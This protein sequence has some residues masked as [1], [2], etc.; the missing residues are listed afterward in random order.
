MR[1]A[2][3]GLGLIIGSMPAWAADPPAAGSGVSMDLDVIAEQFDI[4][5]QQM[6]SQQQIAQQNGAN[7]GQ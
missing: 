3:C 5:R 7:S 4:A 1:L 6:N 2:L